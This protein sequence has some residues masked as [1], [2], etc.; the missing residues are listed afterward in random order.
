MAGMREELENLR[1]RAFLEVCRS[2]A[3]TTLAA[4]DDAVVALGGATLALGNPRGC[5]MLADLVHLPKRPS[6]VEQVRKI[7]Q[8]DAAFQALEDHGEPLPIGRFLEAA[9]EKGAR[10]GGDDQV[11]N[12]R[13]SVSKDERFKPVTRNG[14][15]F[16]WFKERPLPQGWESGGE[17]DLSG[18]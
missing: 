16:W 9:I 18:D 7:S 8:G 3:M 10:V 11:A 17:L 14:L 5:R 6:A 1:N 2:Q 12:F 4:L 13:S 15:Y